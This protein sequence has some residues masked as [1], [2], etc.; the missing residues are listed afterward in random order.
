MKNLQ[1]IAIYVAKKYT[2]AS[3]IPKKMDRTEI[4]IYDIA[5]QLGI[6]ASTVSRALNNNPNINAKTRQRVAECAE[7]LGY[8][9]NPFAANL[10]KQSTSTIGVI[11]HR[12][13]SLFISSFLSGA[14]KAAAARGYNLIIV[15]SFENVD[16]E[17]ANV[18][19]MLEKRVDGL[20]V[21]VAKNSSTVAH[22]KPFIDHNI[23]L[24]F[25]DRIS[26]ELDCATF[27]IDNYS[28]AARMAQ[29]LAEQGCKSIIHATIESTN[30]VYKERIRGFNDALDRLKIKH[31]ALFMPNI[32][33]ESGKNLALQLHHQKQMPD[34]IFFS[35]DMSATG[36]IMG[37][38]E[39][40]LNVPNDIAVAGFNNDITSRIVKPSLTTINYPANELGTIATNHI[41]D[42][43][44][45]VNNLYVTNQVVL[46]SDL[47][48]RESSLRRK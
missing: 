37:A 45:G 4:T 8:R 43:L 11:V 27:A 22:F 10:R 32:D 35:N 41:I 20:L 23:P 5:K 19:T 46:K 36:F 30:M 47:I 26:T 14:E 15:Q 2:F 40:G 12:L 48:V 7:E 9:I 18:K 29:H 24:V 33:F 3:Q 31:K 42:H 17:I 38:Q 13:D 1:P 28:A 16:K 25:F 39:L 44:Q 21:A 34:G 6:S